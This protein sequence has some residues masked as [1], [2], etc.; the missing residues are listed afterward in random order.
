MRSELDIPFGDS[1]RCVLKL[2]EGSAAPASDP[3]LTLSRYPIAGLERGELW[4]VVTRSS[5]P[6]IVKVEISERGTGLSE[7]QLE[8]IRKHAEGIFRGQVG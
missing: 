5:L 4:I 1:K 2:D 6:A 3:E 8:Q 7:P